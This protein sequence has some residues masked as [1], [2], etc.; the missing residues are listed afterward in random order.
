MIP[1]LTAPDAGEAPEIEVLRGALDSYQDR[2]GPHHPLVLA[3]AE[4]LALAWWRQGDAGRALELLDQTVQSLPEDA[5]SQLAD[6]LDLVWKIFFEHGQFEPASRILEEVL[7]RRV[8]AGGPFHPDS[9]A[10]RGDLAIVLH[11][12]G[13]RE[14]AEALSRHALEDARAHLGMR[15]PVTCII[16]WNAVLAAGHRKDAQAACGIAAENLFWLLDEEPAGLDADLR[17]IREWL[18]GRF[19]WNTAPVC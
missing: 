5:D 4:R 2:F 1:F 9:L 13:R 7:E 10:A 19:G 16:A 18:A 6:L 14:Q 17:E 15:D 12:M 8:R 11:R 3:V